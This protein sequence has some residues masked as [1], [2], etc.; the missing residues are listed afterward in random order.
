LN[1]RVR[2]QVTCVAVGTDVISGFKNSI[3]RSS[4]G[5][6]WTTYSDRIFSQQG[7]GIAYGQN[8]WVAAG[9][10]TNTLAYSINGSSWV[11]LGFTVFTTKGQCVHYSP[12]QNLWVVGGQGLNTLAYS[13]DGK[14]WVGLGLILFSVT[15]GIAYSNT[16]NRWVAVGSGSTNYIAYSANG[17]TWNALGLLV[18]SS[19]ANSVSF[20]NGLFVV[21]G[22]GTTNA[23]GWSSDGIS[24]TGTG[25]I[26]GTT[27][28]DQDFGQNKWTIA[29]SPTLAFSTFA[30]S[31]DGKV[32]ATQPQGNS[33]QT[34][35][36]G[37]T[38]S[39]TL[40]LWIG[41]GQG[42]STVWSTDGLTWTAGTNVFSN[43]GNKVACITNNL[44]N[45]TIPPINYIT[46]DITSSLTVNTSIIN[47][48]SNIHV[49]GNLTVNGDLYVIGNWTLNNTITNVF[50]NGTL[51]LIGNTNFIINNVNSTT[52]K[53][54]QTSSSVI[55]SD[56]TVLSSSSQL[57]V[58]LTSDPGIS[59]TTYDLTSSNSVSGTFTSTETQTLY[60]NPNECPSSSVNYGQ[61]ALSVTVSI[62][63]CS[64]STTNNNNSTTKN[65]NNT[66]S[67]SVIPIGAIVGIVIGIVVLGTVISLTIVYV[68]KKNT[69][70]YTDK[71][72]R[73]LK[74]KSIT[75]LRNSEGMKPTAAVNL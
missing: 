27:C 3:A 57:T 12:E 5:K 62:Q 11:G 6:V 40:N 36:F 4:D 44:P 41:M 2:G 25:K 21:S 56:S 14:N 65:P 59:T 64:P 69:A 51:T 49:N 7:N 53:K 28:N 15:N 30:N 33:P 75:D 31:N 74:E 68:T 63:K 72:N 54:R 47:V 48:G 18:F 39:Q 73:M 8:M 32:W 35:S 42:T 55:N 17:Q 58:V 61:T 10:G 19:G 50:V 60:Q 13:F 34:A 38:F 20:A 37:V 23:Q 52:N 24:W 29:G 66:S 46:N 71:K 45:V 1:A 43:S 9:T 70:K 26:F 16:L 67:N 22:V